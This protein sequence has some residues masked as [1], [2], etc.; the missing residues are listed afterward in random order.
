M[1][2]AAKSRPWSDY[3]QKVAQRPVRDLLIQ[4]VERFRSPGVAIDLGCGGGIET[5]ELLRRGWHVVAVDQEAA[6]LDS[7]FGQVPPEARDRLTTQCTAFSAVLL[8][9]ADLIWAGLSLPFCHPEH[10]PRLWEQISTALR[11]GGRFAGDLFGVH[12]AWREDPDM[13]FVTT[14]QVQSLLQ[15]LEVEVL[16]ESE[17]ERQTAF[18]GMQHWHDFA[19]IARKPALD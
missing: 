12:H 2:A 13:T 11:P 10:F 17:E 1:A 5:R 3:Y 6:A 18:R 14:E 7:T 4:A 9:A 16:S 8:P 15:S 19:I